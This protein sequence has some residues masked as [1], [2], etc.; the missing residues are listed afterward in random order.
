MLCAFFYISYFSLTLY[1]S[2]S[3]VCFS[4]A[5]CRHLSLCHSCVYIYLLLSVWDCLTWD[6]D[7]S[8][9]ECDFYIC[10]KEFLTLS[11]CV[12]AVWDCWCWD[13]CRECESVSHALSRLSH[14]VRDVLLSDLHVQLCLCLLRVK[15]WFVEEGHLCSLLL[16]HSHFTDVHS[17]LMI[18]SHANHA[19]S[20]D[21][22]K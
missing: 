13:W 15:Y 6:W 4:L 5:D 21:L 1:Y 11:K 17:C 18:W 7:W 9:R 10:E 22:V 20:L 14:D 2:F 12:R 16:L 3:F 19:F 8:V